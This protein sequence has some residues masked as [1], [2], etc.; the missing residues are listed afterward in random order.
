[1]L[2]SRLESRDSGSSSIYR[3][4]I[5]QRPAFESEH[6]KE[7][8]HPTQNRKRKR[9]RPNQARDRRGTVPDKDPHKQT[10]HRL[11]VHKYNAFLM[12]RPQMISWGSWLLYSVPGAVRNSY[13]KNV[14]G[15]FFVDPTSASG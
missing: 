6:A 1:M 3:S 7:G 5:T 9:K 15:H 12:P 8:R 2:E 14:V 4:S 10:A 11:T 13:R